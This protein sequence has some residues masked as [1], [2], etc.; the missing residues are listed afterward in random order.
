MARSSRDQ[1]QRTRRPLQPHT[2]PT[3]QRQSPG[4]PPGVVG[5]PGRRS[6]ARRTTGRAQ[7]GLARR[8]QTWGSGTAHRQRPRGPARQA[9]RSPP[10]R[11]RETWEIDLDRTGVQTTDRVVG[12][13]FLRVER[14]R[15]R[16]SQ[17]VIKIRI[18]KMKSYMY[19][20]VPQIPSLKAPHIS[21]SFPP[22]WFA[23]VSIVPLARSFL[24]LYKSAAASRLL[25]ASRFQLPSPPATVKA[26]HCILPRPI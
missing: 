24:R 9:G 5:G 20:F 11:G 8:G 22:P 15:K 14:R 17:P 10:R 26:P 13:K 18:V 16:C 25:I 12:L 23:Y 3:T 19:P 21:G 7:G 1:S 6:A 2:H 4:S